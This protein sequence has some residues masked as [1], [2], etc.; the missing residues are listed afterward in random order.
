MGLVRRAA[1]TL[2]AASF[3]AAAQ[4]EPVFRVDVQLV[5]LLATV[6]DVTGRPVGG[7]QKSDFTILD[8]G[9]KQEI[10]VFER[11]TAQP[12]SIAILLDISG[13]TAKEMK[14]QTEAVTRFLKALFGEGNPEDR[15][16]LFA[17]NWETRQV[18][19]YSRNLMRFIE[20]MK[21]LK[22]EA[23]TGLYDAILLA[24]EDIAERDGRHVLVV[25]TDGGDT[26]S[27]TDYAKAM[28][29]AHEADA[30]M[31]PI[32]TMPIMSEAGRNVGGENALTTMS[33]TTGGRL[34]APG[35]NGLDHAFAEILRDLRTQYLIGYYPKNVPPSRDPFHRLTVTTVRSDLRVVTRTGYYGDADPS[36]SP[37]K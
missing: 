37:R 21:G 34:F 12:L 20:G 28:K 9:V 30:V 35:V 32:L 23:G 6:K 29:S 8:N 14:Y 15:A 19:R 33:Q 25:V 18:V 22:A 17:F 31:Y 4:Q 3:V 13:S 26:V 10:A 1:L 36:G 27:A 5:R 16:S 2:L 11:H 7:L 24:S